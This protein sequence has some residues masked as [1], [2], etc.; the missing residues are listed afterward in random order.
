MVC[1]EA[2]AASSA[3]TRAQGISAFGHL[4]LARCEDLAPFLLAHIVRPDA[5]AG[6]RKLEDAAG[7]THGKTLR[8]AGTEGIGDDIDAVEFDG[9]EK[10][11]QRVGKG[12]A[13]RCVGL[14]RIGEHIARR[15]PG[16][17][18]IALRQSRELITPVHGIGANPMQQHNR[19]R[20]GTPGFHI[21]PAVAEI[22]RARLRRDFR[23]FQLGQRRRRKRLRMNRGDGQ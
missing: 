16:H 21:A 4:R 13:V 1:G 11:T 19:R 5:R 3:L 14:E 12:L 22:I 17:D 18:V 2:L 7:I 6:H 15:V 20:V 8:D 10:I 23:E 9:G